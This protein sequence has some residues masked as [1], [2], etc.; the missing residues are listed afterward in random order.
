M[1]SELD[2]RVMRCF[3]ESVVLYPV[4]TDVALSNGENAR[5]VENSQISALRPKVLGLTSGRVYDLA[6]DL[7][8]ASIIIL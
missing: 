8:C 6:N 2:I 3:M 7:S 1:T 4:G 5:V